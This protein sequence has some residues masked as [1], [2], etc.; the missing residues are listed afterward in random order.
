MTQNKFS[1]GLFSG[2]LI[3]RN[4]PSSGCSDAS[5][6]ALSWTRGA[7][8]LCLA[9]GRFKSPSCFLGIVVMAFL[10]VRDGGSAAFFCFAKT[11]A[12]LWLYE[13]SGR[14]PG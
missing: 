14:K 7:A 3:I 12:L 8:S 9:V 1:P 11:H 4:L 10:S 5:T 13:S 2:F 6:T